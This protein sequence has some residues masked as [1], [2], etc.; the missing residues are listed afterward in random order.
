MIYLRH[1]YL[2]MFGI[3]NVASREDRVFSTEL[4]SSVYIVERNTDC[5][6]V[7]HRYRVIARIGTGLNMRAWYRYI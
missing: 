2:I 3:A 6:Y 4:V 1:E 5:T 7:I